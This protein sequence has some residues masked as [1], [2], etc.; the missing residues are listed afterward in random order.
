[1]I[2]SKAA[3]GHNLVDRHTRLDKVLK[4]D[5]CAKAVDSMIAL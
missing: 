5:P 1:L 2:F 3:S 4:D